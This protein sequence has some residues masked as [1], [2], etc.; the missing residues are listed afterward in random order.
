M[1]VDVHDFVAVCALLMLG[2]STASI[3]WI[4][5]CVASVIGA[6]CT[7]AA[8]DVQENDP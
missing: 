2:F 7:K 8:S 3:I 6:A 5:I 1:S 4:V